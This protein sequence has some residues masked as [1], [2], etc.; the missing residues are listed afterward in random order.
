MATRNLVPRANGEGSLGRADKKW[1][2]VYAGDLHVDTILV[3]KTPS[4]NTDVANKLYV[5]EQDESTLQ[6]ANNNTTQEMSLLQTKIQQ[7]YLKKED[8]A[9]TYLTKINASG[10]YLKQSDANA[11]YLKKTDAESTYLKQTDADDSYVSKNG[12]YFKDG[13]EKGGIVSIEKGDG[14]YFQFDRSLILLKRNTTYEVGDIALS[15]NLPSWAYLVCTEAGTTSDNDP[16]F[17]EIISGKTV[18]DGTASFIVRDVKQS[19]KLDQGIPTVVSS[20]MRRYGDD[21]KFPTSYDELTQTGDW[22]SSYQNLNVSGLT[23]GLLYHFSVHQDDYSLKE[24]FIATDNSI[25]VR[26]IPSTASDTSTIPF[27]KVGPGE[28]VVSNNKSPAYF[29]Y[30]KYDS[31]LMISWGASTVPANTNQV[32]VTFPQPYLENTCCMTATPISDKDNTWAGIASLS[33]L[34]GTQFS[35]KARGNGESGI[36][37]YSVL[38]HW[39]AI[40]WWK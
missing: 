12:E 11:N 17:S 18:N 38:C 26:S 27:V 5:D 8:A 4:E 23:S 6:A 29:G 2:A 20:Y 21:Y 19:A 14:S 37:T 35:L 3:E 30:I 34:S 25:W 13:T 32:T 15:P 10:T 16:E 7:G 31:G 9:N 22:I 1:G 24:V 36:Q 40:G 39:H 33:V 28:A